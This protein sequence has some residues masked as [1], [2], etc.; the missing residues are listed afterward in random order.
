MVWQRQPNEFAKARVEIDQF[1]GMV[2]AHAS[3]QGLSART[4]KTD[5]HKDRFVLP[6]QTAQIGDGSLGR[7]VGGV[8]AIGNIGRLLGGA[9][10]TAPGGGLSSLVQALDFKVL[11]QQVAIEEPP[12]LIGPP[13]SL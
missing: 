11:R 8:G 7:H 1:D 5:G 12:W 13:G 3:R 9:A 2:G 6:G 10:V 4:W